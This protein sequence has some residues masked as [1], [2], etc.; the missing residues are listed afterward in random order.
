MNGME[1]TDDSTEAIYL[2]GFSM[3]SQRE[4]VSELLEHFPAIEVSTFQGLDYWH[5]RV[6]RSEFEGEL[7][8]S[9][10]TDAAWLTPRVLAHQAALDYFAARIAFFPL[11]FGTLFSSAEALVATLE[12]NAAVIVEFLEQAE[13]MQEWGLKCFVSWEAA[14]DQAQ[15]EDGMVQPPP[16]GADYLRRKKAIRQRENNLRQVAEQQL[17][18]VVQAALTH[19]NRMVERRVVV[20]QTGEKQ[21]V[22]NWALL[23]SQDK[24]EALCE[25]VAGVNAATSETCIRVEL[26][27]PWPLYSFAPALQAPSPAVA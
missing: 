6:D 15:L 11:S 14:Y 8:E 24:S 23:V 7:G 21:C 22:S 2:L 9:H 10:L 5:L 27:G 18:A 3:N 26:T 13:T 16:T 20:A 4:L 17:V 1:A 19:S 25:W 12:A